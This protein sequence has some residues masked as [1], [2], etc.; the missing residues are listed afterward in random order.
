[1]LFSLTPATPVRDTTP[2]RHQMPSMPS[3]RYALH[4]QATFAFVQR[5]HHY[6]VLIF[7]AFRFPFAF[8]HAALRHFADAA[9]FFRR[10]HVRVAAD[11]YSSAASFDAAF[12]A[13][14]SIRQ[15]RCLAGYVFAFIF[16]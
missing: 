6:A 11:C 8:D 1:M 13:R 16:A 7:F 2:P 4:L 12:S 5:C 10:R 9:F 15:V 14:F 3:F